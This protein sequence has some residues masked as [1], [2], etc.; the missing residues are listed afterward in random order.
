M[1]TS[2]FTSTFFAGNSIFWRRTHFLLDSLAHFS[3][4]ATQVIH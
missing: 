1:A 4:Y 2:S 3:T